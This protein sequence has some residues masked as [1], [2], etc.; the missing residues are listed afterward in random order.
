MGKSYRAMITPSS[1]NDPA[2]PVD[3][4][5]KSP[6]EQLREARRARNLNIEDIAIHLRLTPATVSSLEE[7]DYEKLP[8]PV[9]IRG[10]LS[11]YARLLKISPSSILSAF[12]RRNLA[13]P[14]LSRGIANQS[15]MGSNHLLV[16][17]MTYLIAFCLIALVFFWWRSTIHPSD[18]AR[19]EEFDVFPEHPLEQQ[20]VIFP[21]SPDPESE[22]ALDNHAANHAAPVSEGLSFSTVEREAATMEGD[23]ISMEESA[24][25]EPSPNQEIFEDGRE[26]RMIASP[27]S[28]KPRGP[29]SAE[30]AAPAFTPAENTRSMPQKSALGRLAATLSPARKKD[31]LVV[32]L[33]KDSWVE[34]YDGFGK[35]LFYQLGLSGQTYEFRGSAPFQVVL[36]YAPAAKV[37]YNGKPFDHTPYIQREIAEFPV[38]NAEP[39]NPIR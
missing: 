30:N 17:A 2:I 7:E 34:I 25:T 16:Q 3:E 20:Q 5:E 28:E 8:G 39:T 13:P 35:K 11:A 21:G 29:A 33:S 22:I 26:R 38:G 10:Y 36:G 37:I 18:Y 9:F 6:G 32:R 19:Y 14:P 1:L 23:G 4:Q 12:D 31:R 27:S 24:S 15:Q